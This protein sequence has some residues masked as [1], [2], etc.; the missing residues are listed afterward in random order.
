MFRPLYLN[1]D[2]VR[3]PLSRLNWFLFALGAVMF[4]GFLFVF[5]V[6][7]W[8]WI[9]LRFGHR[10]PIPAAT[11]IWSFS[12]L[13][14]YL[15]GKVWQFIG[16]VFLIRPYGVSAGVC[17]TS[18]ILEMAVFLLANL[19]VA[20]A[21]LVWLG[22]K[23]EPKLRPFLW[24]ALALVP[25]LLIFLHPRI[26]YGIFDWVIKKLRQPVIEQHLRKRELLM[27]GIWGIIGLVWQSLAIWLV[28]QEPLELQFTKWWVVAGA[29]CLAWCAGFLA[30]WAPAG[31]GVR[32]AV[33]MM[34]MQ[35][36][37]PDRVRN[38]FADP[39]VLAGFLAFLAILLRL[40]V[41]AGELLLAGIAYAADFRRKGRTDAPEA[42]CAP[43]P[44]PSANPD[45]ASL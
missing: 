14:R 4:G 34:A 6:M 27:V 43:S 19:L 18:Q 13:A 24:T 20:L 30:F 16:R 2:R 38:E 29:Y 5:R 8:W 17:T 7:P 35:V 42:P 10:M 11:R 15:P 41:T 3:E 22:I 31:L 37:L 25:A 28:I 12:E 39:A 21:C 32:E 26:F 44:Q 23:T 1:W 45:P 9:L 40:L 33:F 36:A